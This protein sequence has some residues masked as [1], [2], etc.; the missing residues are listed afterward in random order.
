MNYITNYRTV[1]CKFNIYKN[2][3]LCFFV[4]LNI[5]ASTSK[6]L[7]AQTPDTLIAKGLVIDAET[8]QPL[9][10]THLIK[11]DTTG[12]ITNQKGCFIIP[13]TPGDNLAVSHLGYKERILS[14]QRISEKSA[15][16]ITFALEPRSY[17]IDAVT[18]RPFDT[19]AEFKQAVLNYRPMAHIE[20]RAIHNVKTLPLRHFKQRSF[21]ENELF[22]NHHVSGY[23]SVTIFSINKDKGILGLI[24]AIIEQPKN[25]E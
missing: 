19:Y 5:L 4:L 11:N 3:I 17:S 25:N 22:I 18:V 10:F 1:N 14:H 16:T 21:Q 13:L 2:I 6:K 8:N 9:P 24:N 7:D 15:D 23:P 20:K 12:Y